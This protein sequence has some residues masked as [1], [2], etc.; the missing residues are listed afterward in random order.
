MTA[1]VSMSSSDGPG[2]MQKHIRLISACVSGNETRVRE[3]LG[4]E[5]WSSRSDG[6]ALRQALVKV[7]TKGNLKVLRL[8]LEHG[9]DV[10]PRKENEL[11]PLFKAAEAGHL[12]VVTELLGRKAD[13]NWRGRNGQTALF[14]AC[15]RGHDAVVSALLEAGA[16]PDGGAGPDGRPGDKDGR[17]PLLVMASE[18]GGRWTIETARLLLRRGVDMNPRDALGRTPL[19]WTA[20]NGHLDLARALLSG[21]FLRLADID[22][23]QNRGKTA[24][25]LAAENNQVDFVDL[26]LGHGAYPDAAS[27]GRWTPLHN[28]SE[29]GHHVIVDKLLAAG[30]NVNAELSN[31]MTPLHW[32]AF[33]G[34]EEVV[35][36][37]LKKPE[38][39]LSVKDQFERTALLCAAERHHKELVHLLSPSRAADRLSEDAREA[40]KQFEATVVDFGDFQEMKFRKGDVHEK[41]KQLVFKHSVYELLYGWE[42]S[43][44]KKPTVPILTKNVKWEPQFRWIHLPA[45]NVAWVE[46]LLAK[47]FVEGGFRDVEG[48][49]ALEKSFDQEHR[50]ALAHD[51]F[52]R[53]HCR[54]VPSRRA[55]NDDSALGV[56][57]EQ[58]AE[59]NAGTGAESTITDT[60]ENS[61]HKAEAKKKG[62]SEQIAERHP[63]RA[64]RK[65]GDPG[66]PPGTKEARLSSSRQPSFA[67]SFA[68]T[69]AFR[70]LVNNGKMVLFMPFLHYETHDRRLNMSET[71]RKARRGVPPP[72][73]ASRDELLI[74][75]YINQ[76][77]PRRT[78]DQFL[79][80][81][82]D[83]TQRDNDQVVWR[84]CEKHR[85][86]PKVFMVDQLWL[87]ILGGDTVITCF[88]QRWDQP[89]QDPLN[90]VDGIVE[91]T[92]A[93]TRPP[94]QSVYDLAMVITGRAS[95]MFDRHRFDEQQY[96]FL[97]MFESSIG[98]VT[99]K[100]SQLFSKFHRASERS[101]QWVKRYRRGS[102]DNME[103]EF[104]DDL[105]NIHQETKLLAEIKDI[106]DEL[107][108]I[109]VVLDSQILVLEDLMINI[110]EE[111]SLEGTRK[112]T[113]GVIKEIKRRFEE[114]QR[115]ILVH[116]NDIVRMNNQ[117]AS[118][119]D[120]LT[121]LLDLKQKHSN[122]LE[123]R[124]AREQAISAAKQGQTVMV[125]T[126]VTII[127]LPMS[128]IAAF[129]SIDVQEWGNQLTIAYVSKW[130]FGIG[131]AISFV[132]IAMAF[133]VHDISDAWKVFLRGAHKYTHVTLSHKK[134][135]TPRGISGGGE[136]EQPDN[137]STWTA[138]ATKP[139]T[140]GAA[141]T[142]AYR[143]TAEDADW[144]RRGLEGPDRMYSRHSGMSRDRERYDHAML[145]LSPLRRNL[146]IGSGPG[147]PWARPSLDGR[148]V[149]LSEDLERGREPG[150]IR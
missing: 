27:D 21:E 117:A 80:H 105:L 95:G 47:A 76:L 87:W 52:M 134:G 50:G 115:L 138:R 10:H 37:L 144:K 54:R 36:L 65:K 103:H 63:T 56:L 128:F 84:Y 77:H 17:T 24:L 14:P 26:L 125:F 64:K 139:G 67:P 85:F 39:N 113:D 41:K 133:L 11:S 79:Y 97:D 33:N 73:N 93:K 109:A 107:K 45:N 127:F 136:G 48:F 98:T 61:T 123:A 91:E 2:P 122:A 94:I 60:S 49:K 111:L 66:N 118:I 137:M 83:T 42:D 129:F 131:L 100:E 38:T 70:Q 114:Q 58:T 7:A 55:A 142:S 31:R 146:S 22:A 145:G 101:T 147:V 106:Q 108:I 4:G 53:T 99:D 30:A 135:T 35:R 81:G 5:P 110:T 124:F 96:Q 130:M 120:G 89:K 88:P 1:A 92:N 74:Y 8:L 75:A 69:G 72:R 78:L 132:F 40:S 62:K 68:S 112:S 59:P 71:I 116:R 126:I 121:N 150:Q 9:A 28:A 46:T 18:K 140:A 15:M 25:H 32:A 141:S 43:E 23:A 20:K 82:I 6:D 143:W 102:D 90:V 119:Y 148:R 29:K 104:T 57:S 16:H 51:T 34:H 19:H 149:R 3:A 13:P 44:K 12:A 86:E